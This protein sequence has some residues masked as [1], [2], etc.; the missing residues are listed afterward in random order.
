MTGGTGD[1][2]YIVDST[3]DVVQE[4]D[5][6]SGGAWDVVDASVNYSLVASSSTAG[7]EGLILSGAATTGRG[8]A[9]SNGIAGNEQANSLYGEDGNDTIYGFGGND[10]VW[11]GNGHD[12][13]AG[14]AGNDVLYGEAGNDVLEGGEGND[15]LQGGTGNDTYVFYSGFGSDLINNATTTSSTDLDVVQ[16]GD[17]SYNT[18]WFKQV[19]NNLE[20]S[21]VG[22]TDK[23]QVQN[24]FSDATVRIDQFQSL[25]SGMQLDASKVAGLVSAMA[26]FS[27]QDM[28]SGA[29]AGLIA[30]RDAAWQTISA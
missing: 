8:N 21:E 19:G 18:L 4:S 16:F 9:L 2:Y 25:G 22:T 6:V 26:G 12:V 1:D 15:T 23:V 17:A 3:G 11:G 30:A 20:I 24:W 7:V 27:P 14:D 10:S 13:L 28:S 29:P 5:T